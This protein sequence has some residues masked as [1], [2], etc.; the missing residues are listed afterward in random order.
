[1]PFFKEP[2]KL[3]FSLCKVDLIEEGTGVDAELP[4]GHP[5]GVQ[6]YVVGGRSA[7]ENGIM[8]NSGA[9]LSTPEC[10]KEQ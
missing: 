8:N 7:I 2:I 5:S 6:V 1:M 3:R 9:D 10:S 4:N